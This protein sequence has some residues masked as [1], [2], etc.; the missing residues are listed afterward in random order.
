MTPLARTA[1]VLALSLGTACQPY[2]LPGGG[3]DDGPQI[4]DRGI[5]V[6]VPPPSLK[7]FPIQ[8]VDI[9]GELDDMDPEPKT[10]VILWVYSA[11]NEH[12]DIVFAN[13]DGTF[14]FSEVLIDLTDNCI[15]V[16]AEEPGGTTSIHSFFRASIGPDDQTIVTEQF[17][18]GC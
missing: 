16:W 15:E 6:P 11:T 8:R 2:H 9:D 13:S 7:E 14:H 3:Y 12:G 5:S 1:L 17:F 4:G 18:S 10:E